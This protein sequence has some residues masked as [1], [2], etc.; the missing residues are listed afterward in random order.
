MSFLPF[1][2]LYVPL[3]M[4]NGQ[5]LTGRWKKSIFNT[6]LTFNITKVTIQ[7]KS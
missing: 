4:L 1:R 2:V 5:Q 3:V 6:A 7:N